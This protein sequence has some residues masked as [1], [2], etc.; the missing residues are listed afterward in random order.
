MKYDSPRSRESCTRMLVCRSDSGR[1]CG[2]A[3]TGAAGLGEHDVEADRAQQR[4]LAGHVRAGDE[5][6]RPGGTDRDVVADSAVVGRSADV[7]CLRPARRRGPIAQAYR[8][9]GLSRRAIAG[10]ERIE[11]A[12]APRASRG[13]A[14]V[15]PT[16][17]LERKEHMEVP[18]RQRLHWEVE[19]RRARRSSAKPR[20]SVGRRMQA[21]AG[22]PSADRRSARSRQVS[23][24][25]GAGAA[26]VEPE[27]AVPDVVSK[28][29]AAYRPDVHPPPARSKIVPNRSASCNDNTSPAT[30][31]RSRGGVNHRCGRFA[32]ISIQIVTRREQDH[33][34]KAG[35]RAKRVA[36]G[37]TRERVDL[38]L[39]AASSRA[40]PASAAI[41]QATLGD[42][43]LP[44]ELRSRRGLKHPVRK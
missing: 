19:D 10:S 3:H 27:G 41:V 16:P 18:Q 22:C 13:R 43:G 39:P 23:R 2:V 25:L 11:L 34:K 35:E 12:D 4:A 29:A 38:L 6:H 28:M 42:C 15:P 30:G 9:D 14:A 26:R 24:A 33:A 36:F 17:P 40:L 32:A 20:I 44:L 8:P 21:G 37:P 5:Q 1:S 7:R 31:A